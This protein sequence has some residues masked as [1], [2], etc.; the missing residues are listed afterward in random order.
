M[1]K[2]SV[3]YTDYK[4]YKNN[5]TNMPIDKLDALQLCYWEHRIKFETNNNLRLPVEIQSHRDIA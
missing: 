2:H 4:L 3:T 1:S 5:T